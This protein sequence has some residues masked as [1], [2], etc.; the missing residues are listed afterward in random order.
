[1]TNKEIHFMKSFCKL[2]RK[3]TEIALIEG[4]PEFIE[5]RLCLMDLLIICL[6]KTNYEPCHPER[7]DHS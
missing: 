3:Y 2:S 7:S 6:N 1:M 5:E 4:H